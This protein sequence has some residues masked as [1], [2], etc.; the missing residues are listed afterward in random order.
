MK[1]RATLLSL[2]LLFVVF[3]LAAD[4]PNFSGT[5]VLDKNKSFSNPPGFDQ[6]MTVTHIAEV[7]GS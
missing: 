7:S 4:K 3:S 1:Y 5:W 6:T 2:V